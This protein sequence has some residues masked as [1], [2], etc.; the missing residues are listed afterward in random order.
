MVSVGT[1]G[2]QQKFDDV[3]EAR[4]LAPEELRESKLPD[5]CLSSVILGFNSRVGEHY[6]LFINV[7]KQSAVLSGYD[8]VDFSTVEVYD[9]QTDT[10]TKGVDIP[11]P[12][13]GMSTSVVNERIY[14]MGGWSTP[15]GNGEDGANT[16][17]VYVSDVII[18]FNGDGI[19]DSADMCIMVD[20]WGT[21]N[22]RC[23]IGPTPLG[24]GVIDVEDLKVLAKHL[25]EKVNDPTLLAHWAFD[26]TAGDIAQD[27]AGDNDAEIIGGPVWLPDGGQV[28][29]AI[30]LDGLDDV[31]VGG[32]VMN[33]ASG[34]FSVLAWVKGGVAGQT[35]ISEQNGANCL[36]ADPLEGS[37]IEMR[38][39]Q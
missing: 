10:W 16:S 20:A 28:G 23:D 14:V 34:P 29:G 11:V 1:K 21:D 32:P 27:S 24:D 3:V 8:K 31:I 19:V 2:A 13:E 35:V 36:S 15:T 37:L 38:R 39:H 33:L 12:T 6:E 9:P 22:S 25:Y 4:Y 30:Q 5:T 7:K 26:E 17:A 18:D